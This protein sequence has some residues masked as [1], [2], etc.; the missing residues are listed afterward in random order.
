MFELLSRVLR[1]RFLPAAVLLLAFSTRSW[2]QA[3][4]E[5]QA[6]QDEVSAEETPATQGFE[7]GYTSLA[8]EQ[9]D[10][11]LGPIALYPDP[12]L[13]QV[14]AAATYP[15]DVIQAARFLKSSTDL[16][17]LDQMGLDPS[18]QALARYPDL[19]K[20]MDEQLEWTNALG[21]A[22]LNQQPD[23]MA[24]V[25]R[26]RSLAVSNGAL[27]DTP[28]QEIYTEE[29]F[30]GILP[31]DPEIIYVPEYVPE[32]V[33]GWSVPPIDAYYSS[34]S[35]GYGYSTG[36]WLNLGF[37]WGSRCVSY[38]PWPCGPGKWVGGGKFCGT[39]Y[40]RAGWGGA[41]CRRGGSP[42]PRYRGG[43]GGH[44]WGR[45]HGGSRGGH[46][47]FRGRYGDFRGGRGN[48]PGDGW[49][50]GSANGQGG[51]RD[52][53]GN[54]RGGGSGSRF[55]NAPRDGQRGGGRNGGFAS[56]Q[57]G[58]RDGFGSGQGGGSGSRF[59]SGPRDGQRG[60]GRNGGFG[61]GV[62]GRP[63]SGFGNGQ[64]SGQRIGGFGFGGPAGNTGSAPQGNRGNPGFGSGPRSDRR[65]GSNTTWGGFNNGQRN[66]QNRGDAPGTFQNAQ[67]RRRS[68]GVSGGMGSRS[69]SNGGFNGF[70][71]GPRRSSANNSLGGS[72]PTTG[73]NPR[74]LMNRGQ[75]YR[76]GSRN[77]FQGGSR[78]GPSSGSWI[79]GSRSR[80]D[81]GTPRI[82]GGNSRSGGSSPRSFIGGGSRGFSRGGRPSG[83]NVF[84]RGGSGSS[85]PRMQAR[86]RG[87]SMRSSGTSS[88]RGFRSG[89][90][91]GG[92]MRSGGMR[93]G[94]GGTGRS[95]GGRGR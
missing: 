38:R 10:E 58:R 56:G 63:G 46:G 33:Y 86:S 64:R 14:L 17:Q 26:L 70:G 52:G 6:A 54:G 29:E 93:S 75:P 94:G 78:P 60:D 95:G 9:L 7:T 41:W 91:R 80:R 27:K 81:G 13:A 50:G 5:M 49:R 39:Y 62:R 45:G 74:G 88:P 12:L 76:G 72:R 42:L 69:G 79:G 53:F 87:P 32:V 11:L 73:G 36:S 24:A 77:A 22:F 89:G 21:A 18:V 44:G 67:P 16:S 31:A 3:P 82:S 71:A 23:V 8:P 48:R 30:V 57:G 25:Q 90:M 34:I 37:N 55:G 47:G 92:G 1:S 2:A 84:Q 4:D 83:G 66:G 85:G 59:G 65:P 15:M 19:L 61:N 43:H 28:Q 40:G 51:R 68:D 20:R 35:F